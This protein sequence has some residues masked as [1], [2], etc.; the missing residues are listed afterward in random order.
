MRQ[1]AGRPFTIVL[2]VGL[3]ASCIVGRR[4]KQISPIQLGTTFLLAAEVAS[5]GQKGKRRIELAVEKLDAVRGLLSKP[6]RIGF[7]NGCIDEGEVAGRKP[8]VG[9]PCLPLNE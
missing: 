3:P 7:Q 9:C 2:A 5:Y 6:V 4:D 8:S 1:A